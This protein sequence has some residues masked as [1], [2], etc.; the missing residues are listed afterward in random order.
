MFEQ[1]AFRDRDRDRDPALAHT[2][3]D[4]TGSFRAHSSTAVHHDEEEPPPLAAP[5]FRT[6]F[7]S[8]CSCC[9][10]S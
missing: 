2:G 3:L 7:R 4:W 6:N 9:C 1:Q 8:T 5:S 10:R